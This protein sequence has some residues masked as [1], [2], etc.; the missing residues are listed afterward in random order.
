MLLLQGP[1]AADT[2]AHEDAHPGRDPSGFVDRLGHERGQ[3]GLRHR[4]PQDRRAVA[5]PLRQVGAIQ[6]DG[7]AAGLHDAGKVTRQ[8]TGLMTVDSLLTGLQTNPIASSAASTYIVT[9]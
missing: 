7:A 4:E 8:I 5:D 6:P 9:M 1:D 3:P 2:G